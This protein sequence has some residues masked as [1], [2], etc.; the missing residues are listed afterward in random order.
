VKAALPGPPVLI[1]R[2]QWVMLAR[3]DC[4]NAADIVPPDTEVASWV[5]GCPAGTPRIFSIVLWHLVIVATSC[6]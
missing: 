4:A 6:L 5:A 1:S 3:S 2:A